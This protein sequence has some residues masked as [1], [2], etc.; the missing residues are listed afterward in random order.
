MKHGLELTARLRAL[1]NFLYQFSN[2]GR[3][4][5]RAL[6]SLVEKLSPVE[7]AKGD[8]I[9]REGDPPGPMY[10]IEQGR[11]RVH[12][13]K[14]GHVRDLAFYREGDYF[15]ELSILNDSP[16]AASVEAVTDVRLLALAPEAVRELKEEHPEF[17]RL[18]E[19]RLA[20]YSASTEARVPLDFAS[21]LLPAE[22]R[23]ARQDRRR[24]ASSAR[25]R[26]KAGRRIRSPTSA[27]FFRQRKER[28]RRFP[29]VQ[30]ID[31]MDCGAASLAMV[32][33]HFGRNV[34][35]PRIRELCHT[36]RD[37][38]SLKAICQA[39]TE[40]GL[41]ARALKVSHAQSARSCRCRPSCT[42]RAITGWCCTT[43][44]RRTCAWPIR[45]W[46]PRRIPRAEF[47]A[48]WSGYA[49][50]FDYTAEFEKSPL[51][52]FAA[53][54]ARAVPARPSHRPA[55]G[56]VSRADRHVPAAALPGL[57]PDGGGQGDR[58]KQ[59][60][61]AHA[62]SSLAM[63]FALI[64][65]QAAN[66]V[67]QYLL[68]F[69]AVRIDAAILDFLTRQLL[70]LP[71]T[72]F[73]SR[74][75]GDIQRRLDGARQVRQF[76]VQF[77][78][79]GL[80]ALVTLIGALALVAIYS[81]LLA[82]VFLL[83]TPLYVGMMVFSVKVL[84]PL[85][86]DIEESQ[87]KYSSHQI[88]AIKGIEAVKAASAELT[89]RDAMLNEFLSVS[90]KMFRSNFI[91]MSYDSVL[92][93]V[94]LISTALFL[95]VGATQVIKGHLSVGALRRV[96]FADGDG[97]RRHAADARYLGSVAAGLVLLNRLNDIFEPEPEQGRDRSRLAAVPSMEGH[98]EL[99]DV[100]FR[101]G[102]PEAP[103]ILKDI[104]LEF[105][106]GTDHRDRRAQR[107]RKD[108]AGQAARGAGRTDRG[109]HPLRSRRPQ[110]A[111]LPRR[112][113]AHRHGAAGEPHVRRHD[114]AQHRLRRSRAGVRAR[115][116]VRADGQRA[117][118]HHAPAARVRDARSASRGSA[119]RAD[120]SSASPSRERS[121]WIRRSSSSTKPPARSTPSPSGPSRQA[122]GG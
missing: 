95:W 92:Q 116:A 40:L 57:H 78:I 120:R 76:A 110:D 84:R 60:Q 3:L 85:L 107:Q 74:R 43:S 28:I 50:L 13:H 29:Y 19:E 99:R 72:Y 115:A 8:V 33:R 86:A 67:Q 61:P 22:T 88:D 62:P 52:V 81:P 2:F 16:R 54:E 35:L 113:P 46:E 6:H 122:S 119:C 68:S 58:G 94:G 53:E 114:R 5:Q 15:G 23:G 10:V 97:L 91:I 31:E 79:G 89:F 104:D 36:S 37:G 111:E 41:A 82:G 101:Y 34:S 51:A 93:T 117:R 59:R 71:T 18:L 42:G 39:A 11:V 45:R 106:P 65:M 102:G 14:N 100:G 49:A 17:R 75:T 70:S 47:E 83:T 98:I 73:S 7:Y 55:A 64:F 24:R 103:D 32:C 80:L 109:H 121:T 25:T 4:P 26:T 69:A 48:K 105:A 27:G 30:Q 96:Q 118:L 20:Q 66:L 44:A 9:V 12:A 63:V 21:E 108:D 56:A 87:G 112:A 1:S 77:G 90:K 38:T